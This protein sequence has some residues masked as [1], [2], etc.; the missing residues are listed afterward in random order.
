[1]F[2]NYFSKLNY[3]FNKSDFSKFEEEF[4]NYDKSK[5][6]CEKSY[7]LFGIYLQKKENYHGAAKYFQLAIAKKSTFIEAKVNLAFIHIKYI[8]DIKTAKQLLFDVL[9]QD[10]NNKNANFIFYEEDH[11]LGNLIKFIA[12]KDPNIVYTGYNI[13]HPSEKIMNVKISTKKNN[14]HVNSLVLTLRTICNIMVILLNST[15]KII[16][17]KE[18]YLPTPF[19]WPYGA[20]QYLILPGLK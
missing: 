13:P 7:N 16:E 19:W 1:M 12:N 15:Y 10:I 18:G 3:L 2:E 17:N 8:K 5:L 11:S 9:G 20:I 6:L 14:C 4:F